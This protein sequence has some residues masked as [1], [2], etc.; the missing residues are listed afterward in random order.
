[1]TL[2]EKS[3][4]MLREEEARLI[5]TSLEQSDEDLLNMEIWLDRLDM[6]LQVCSYLKAVLIDEQS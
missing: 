3:E 5:L 1:M 2:D 6:T 4:S